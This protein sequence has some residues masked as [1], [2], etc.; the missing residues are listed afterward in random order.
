MANYIVSSNDPG[1]MGGSKAKEDII[2]FAKE[3]GYIPFKIDPYQPNKLAKLYYANF[4]MMK[5]FKADQI[6][7]VIIQYPIPSRYMVGKFMAKLKQKIQGKLV[8]WIHDIQGLQ[9]GS[10]DATVKWELDLFNTANLL[11]V[12]NTKM[13]QWLSDHGVTTEKVVLK[14]FDYDNPQ[15]IQSEQPYNRTVCFAGNL[16]KSGFIKKLRTKNKFYVFGSN[17]PTEHGENTIYAGQYPPTELTAHLTQ[18]Y[19]LIWD[20]PSVETC[21]GVFG[22]YL[23]FNNPHKTS[24]YISSGIPIVIWDQAAL[25]DFVLDNDIGVVV[26]ELTELDS[27]LDGVSEERYQQMKRNVSQMAVRLRKGYY[28]HRAL[29]AV[30]KA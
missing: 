20:G 3:D 21:A 11:I 24:L 1:Q 30:D 10:D 27:V 12:H 25:A 8:I 28:T 19:G 16:F 5:F 29:E 7:N 6:D 9:S 13:K 26:S 4:K 18:N 2:K 15:P 22:H 23:L 14:I 17:M